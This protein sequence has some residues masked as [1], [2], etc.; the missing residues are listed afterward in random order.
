METWTEIIV[1]REDLDELNHVNNKEYVGYLE[2]ARG[3]W[4]VQSGFSFEM[5]RKHDLGTV[6]VNLTITF[7]KEAV[8]GERL[9]VKTVPV[10]LGNTSFDLKQEI[11]N[12]A[13]EK[14][15]EAMVTSVMFDRTERKSVPVVK[16][17]ACQF[18]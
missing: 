2:E 13:D 10:R 8:Y 6:V 4:Y 17:I 15:T 1:K 14:I 16:E 9:K 5:M 12:Q 7:L 11:F 3:D 18:N